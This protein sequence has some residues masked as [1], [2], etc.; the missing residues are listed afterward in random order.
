MRVINFAMGNT[1]MH[2]LHFATMKKQYNRAVSIPLL[3]ELLSRMRTELT[4]KV[5]PRIIKVNQMLYS[6]A[7]GLKYYDL[8]PENIDKILNIAVKS[9]TKKNYRYIQRNKKMQKFVEYT[10][11]MLEAINK[12]KEK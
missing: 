11:A 3:L 1:Y 8:K 4:G 9:Y 5:D 10:L 6:I 7:E 2:L 12:V